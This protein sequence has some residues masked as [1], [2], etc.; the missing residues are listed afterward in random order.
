MKK[1]DPS[2]GGLILM[3]VG[4]KF[5]FTKPAEIPEPKERP[6]QFFFRRPPHADQP[7]LIIV[8]SSHRARGPRV[9]MELQ[10]DA[11]PVLGVL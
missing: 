3:I 7:S 1:R 9:E 4:I 8:F 6:P 5:F 11:A 2:L 10:R